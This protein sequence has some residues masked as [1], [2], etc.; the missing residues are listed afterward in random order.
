VQSNKRKKEKSKKKKKKKKEMCWLVG[1]SKV[2]G[3]IVGSL[4][5]QRGATTYQVFD[6]ALLSQGLIMGRTTISSEP[7][8]TTNRWQAPSPDRPN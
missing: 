1:W 8:L 3:S 4:L 2:M 7:P 5:H 6:D